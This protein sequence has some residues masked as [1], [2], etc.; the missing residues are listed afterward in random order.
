L[1]GVVLAA[2]LAAGATAAVKKSH[3]GGT[4]VF[5]GTADPTLL[6]PALVS[7]GESFRATEQMFETLVKLKPGT[8]KLV[9]DL[10]TKWAT[11][12]G[13]KTVTFTLRKGVKFT[14]GTPFNAK[15]VCANFNRWYNWTGPFQ[16]G[17]ATYYYQAAFGGFKKNESSNLSAP[18]YKSC[19]AKGSSTAVVNLTKA[20][21]TFINWL[22]LQAFA[23]QSP[24]AMK[25]Y[26]AD[27]GTISGGAFKATGSYGFSHPTGTGPYQFVSWTIGQKLELKRN[28][29]YWGPKAKLDR[30]IIRPISANT[31][32]LQALQTG[33][34]NAYDLAAPQDVPT[35]QGNSGLKV[36][37]R[38][39]FNVAYVTINSAHKP[40]NNPLVRQ[41]VAY[42]LDRQSVVKNFYYGTG[43]VAD[44]FLP[45]GLFGWTNKVQKYPYDPAKAKA[46]LQQAGLSLPVPV[47]FWYPTGVS[48]PYMPD[49]QRNFQAF[50]ASLENSGFKVTVH[51]APWRPDYVAKVNS[52]DAGDLNLI[53]WTGDFGDPDNFV[54]T[55]FK[56]YS[57]Q[58]GWRNNQIQGLLQ[59]AAAETNL[60]KRTAMYQKASIMLSKAVPAVPYV[61]ATPALGAQKKVANL[62]A[63]PTG[64]VWFG[65][66]SVGGQ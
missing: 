8:L 44:Q 58:F 65:D 28:P 19:Q 38:P 62:V 37:K 2:V 66:T 12:N 50:A 59:K 45:P 10:A 13:G 60:K 55:F 15:A 7:D 46:L 11:S 22:V 47:D 42:G 16:D 3:A 18:L 56:T 64:G 51:S 52:G 33:D 53:G 24:T 49:P 23:M 63:T 41:A 39:A 1:I 5:G 31:A 30:L 27:E 9:P 26:G 57:P 36:V 20:T 34:V 40:F 6:D 48:R 32:R 35:I 17:G 14:D 25:K 43:K 54:G 29:N 61:N 21:G 4:L